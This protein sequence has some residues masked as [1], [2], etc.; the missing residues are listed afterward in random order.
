M[1]RKIITRLNT[2]EGWNAISAFSGTAC[3]G[4]FVLYLFLK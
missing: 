4:L 3:L 2:S 1:T